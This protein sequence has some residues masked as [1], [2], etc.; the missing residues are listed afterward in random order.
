MAE[1]KLEC[2]TEDR[3]FL[4]MTNTIVMLT[5]IAPSADPKGSNPFPR[6]GML[7]QAEE[8]ARL[9]PS[10]EVVILDARAENN[11]KEGHLPGAI[12]WDTAGTGEKIDA[13]RLAKAGI[14]PGTRVIVYDDGIVRDA[15]RLWWRLKYSGQEKVSL[16]DG[17]MVAWKA[18]DGKLSTVQPDIKEVKVQDRTATDRLA[19]RKSVV[20]ILKNKS[21][22]IVDAR[23][24]KEYCGETK[25]AK[26]G[27]SI[28]GAVNLEWTDLIDAKTKKFKSADELAK[29]FKDA[30][31]D[32]DKPVVTY[33]QSGG[34]A[35]VMAFGLELMG[36]KDVRNY[37][38]SWAE[39]GNDPDLPIETPK[40]KK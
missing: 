21:A 30:G 16:L 5:L 29:L 6:S 33:C 36:A 27:G 15:A 22:Q 1:H 19:T 3:R 23:S 18:A 26:R 28:P 10:N 34:R 25:Q 31:I 40:P 35:S 20:E 24:E 39:W 2:L 11:Y 7:V 38:K 8:L 17:G 9:L 13:E 4:M 12:W 14:A 32:P 37:Y